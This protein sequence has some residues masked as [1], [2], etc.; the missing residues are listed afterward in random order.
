MAGVDDTS[1]SRVPALG[2]SLSGLQRCA[3][4]VP[5]VD[6]DARDAIEPGGIPQHLVV[7]EKGAVPPIVRDQTSESKAKLRVVEACVRMVAGGKREC[8]SSHAHHSLAALA[9]TA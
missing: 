3:D 2:K 6:Q 4:V 7:A 8:V 9:R 1:L 5:T